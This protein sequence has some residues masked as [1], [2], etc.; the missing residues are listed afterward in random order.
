M[1]IWLQ[2]GY[3]FFFFLRAKLVWTKFLKKIITAMVAHSW[4][5]EILPL[6]IENQK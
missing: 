2:F 4:G 5:L 1:I 6:P 3:C